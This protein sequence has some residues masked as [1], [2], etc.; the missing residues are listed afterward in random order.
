MT[1]QE[2][3]LAAYYNSI[4][5]AELLKLAVNRSSFIDAA[6]QAMARELLSRNLAQGKSSVAG[7]SEPSVEPEPHGVRRLVT[8]LAHVLAGQRK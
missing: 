7:W 2:K 3:A 8:R 5:D 4:T 6:Q 1:I